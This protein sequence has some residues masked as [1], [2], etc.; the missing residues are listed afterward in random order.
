VSWYV[1]IVN[2][3]IGK[4]ER[5]LGPFM[6]GQVP[7]IVADLEKRFEN[8]VFYAR[9]YDETNPPKPQVPPPVGSDLTIEQLAAHISGD[10]PERMAKENLAFVRFM[11]GILRSGGVWGWPATGTFWTKTATGFKRH[12]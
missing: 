5:V 8:S 11:H 10:R 6:E 1:E 9:G 2:G 7:T 4:I 12:L 3:R